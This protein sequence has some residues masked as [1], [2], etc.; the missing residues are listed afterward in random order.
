MVKDFGDSAPMADDR[1]FRTNAAT[2]AIATSGVLGPPGRVKNP[3]S[4]VPLKELA[5]GD[6]VRVVSAE[7]YDPSTQNKNTMKFTEADVLV[8]GGDMFNEAN[9]RAAR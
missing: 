5:E 2:P 1:H 8:V 3:F 9:W 7:I 4:G 6:T